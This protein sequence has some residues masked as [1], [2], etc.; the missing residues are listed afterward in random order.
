MQPKS[1]TVQIQLDELLFVWLNSFQM[2]LVD[3][4]KEFLLP[5][6]HVLFVVDHR[7][8]ASD[9]VTYNFFTKV[10]RKSAS[11]SK[12]WKQSWKDCPN[13]SFRLGVETGVSPA[14]KILSY[15]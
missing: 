6:I 5:G 4:I 1:A 3:L 12:V 11:A 8:A 15:P 10:W 14:C 13:P 9:V 7:N 2:T